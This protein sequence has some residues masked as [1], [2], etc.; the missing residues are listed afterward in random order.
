MG[1]SK[2]LAAPRPNPSE[3]MEGAVPPVRAE[4]LV[5]VVAPTRELVVQIFNVVAVPVAQK[6]QQEMHVLLVVVMR[7]V[8]SFLD[9]EQKPLVSLAVF[10]DSGKSKHFEESLFARAMQAG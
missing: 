7:S 8:R 1:K 10:R 2:K 5:L 6:S 3:Y 9:L 4:P